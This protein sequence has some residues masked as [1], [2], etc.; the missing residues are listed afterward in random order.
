VGRVELSCI[1]KGQL[2]SLGFN[3]PRAFSNSLRHSEPY[4]RRISQT[5]RFAQSD[6]LVNPLILRLLTYYDIIPCIPLRC[7]LI[8][9]DFVMN[10][11]HMCADKI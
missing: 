8:P 9:F 7:R 5:L 1:A 3:P 2:L 10:Q 11:R 6:R 4:G